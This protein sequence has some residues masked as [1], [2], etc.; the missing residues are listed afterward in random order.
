MLS[1]SKY[2]KKPSPALANE[3]LPVITVRI[4]LADPLVPLPVSEKEFAADSLATITSPFE[5]PPVGAVQLITASL[6]TKASA[7]LSNEFSVK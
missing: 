3:K 7:V 2:A 5:I 4:P 1:E 6:P